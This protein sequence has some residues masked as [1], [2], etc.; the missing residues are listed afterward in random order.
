[1]ARLPTC[2]NFHGI[3]SVSVLETPFTPEDCHERGQHLF[4]VSLRYR[5]MAEHLPK[6][7]FIDRKLIVC[8]FPYVCIIHFPLAKIR[9]IVFFHGKNIVINIVRR[10][11]GKLEGDSKRMKTILFFRKRKI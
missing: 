10:R 4:R 8:V 11:V 3:N 9:V 1:M 2:R 7:Q 6:L 5:S